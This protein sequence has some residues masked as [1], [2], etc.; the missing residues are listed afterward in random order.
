[1]NDKIVLLRQ[2]YAPVSSDPEAR[3]FEAS[4]RVGNSLALIASIVRLQGR[5]LA[6]RT[7]PVSVDDVRVLLEEVGLR[8]EA[9][10]RLHRYLIPTD[11]PDAID[12][13]NYLRDVAQAALA[14]LSLKGQFHLSFDVSDESVVPSH[15]ALLAGLVVNELVMNAIKHAHPTAVA[16][17]LLIGCSR[18]ADMI[19]VEVTD[20][21]VGFPEGFEPA[22]DGEL[23]L[24][25]VRSLALQ[26]KGHLVLE[27]T[28]IGVRALLSFPN[29][30]KG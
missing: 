8:L 1:M 9:V 3:A 23:G 29:T 24:Q 13:V 5:A 26:L 27:D 4:H 28:G 6:K 12:L 15:T 25:L 19:V 11:N 30:L 18:R 22:T 14:S 20:D 10:G 21:G 7:T 2:S 16:G 17:Q